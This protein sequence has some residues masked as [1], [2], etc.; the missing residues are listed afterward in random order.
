[1]VVKLSVGAAGP[2]GLSVLV[3]TLLS[4][5]Q[6]GWSSDLLHR[7]WAAPPAAAGWP[8]DAQTL[9]QHHSRVIITFFV[10]LLCIISLCI[11]TFLLLQQKYFPSVTRI[12][13]CNSLFITRLMTDWTEGDQDHVLLTRG[14]ISV[15]GRFLC[16]SQQI[17]ALHCAPEFLPLTPFLLSRR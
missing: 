8:G 5:W 16:S 14:L 15:T 10:T 2:S 9:P 6:P 3:W 12:Q 1:M 4:G 11:C 13:F 7:P 17:P